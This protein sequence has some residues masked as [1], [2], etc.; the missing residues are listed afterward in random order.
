[1]MNWQNIRDA[2]MYAQEVVELIEKEWK[3]VRKLRKD[4]MKCV[5]SILARFEEIEDE[6]NLTLKSLVKSLK[7]HRKEIISNAGFVK[8]HY[9]IKEE[10]NE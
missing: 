10:K 5:E 6:I 1:M 9:I 4:E 2:R 8:R 3:F 7:L